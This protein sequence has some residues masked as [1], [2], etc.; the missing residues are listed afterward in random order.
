MN[1]TVWILTMEVNRHDQYG[2]YFINVY[3][4]KPTREQLLVVDEIDDNNVDHILAGGGRKNVED[5][6]FHLNEIEPE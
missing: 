5:F 2:Q 3:K 6:F 1:N 4:N